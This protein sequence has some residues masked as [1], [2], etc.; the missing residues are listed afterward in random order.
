VERL[1]QE[2]CPKTKGAS[3]SL[4]LKITL[5]FQNTKSREVNRKI[6]KL[7]ISHKISTM[8]EIPRPKALDK[9][10]PK[11]KPLPRSIGIAREPTRCPIPKARVFTS[12]PRDL[13]AQS[14]PPRLQPTPTKSSATACSP[15]LATTKEPCHPEAG[16]FCPP[17]D[18]CILPGPPASARGET[19]PGA[20]WKSGLS[21]PRQ[22][23]KREIGL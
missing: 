3:P 4:R 19:P 9:I 14:H 22:S 11:L 23:N 1:T 6:Y 2:A 7:Y 8:Q 18:L 10:F 12:G 21:H 16:A 15:T 20:P 5:Y 13:V 17:K